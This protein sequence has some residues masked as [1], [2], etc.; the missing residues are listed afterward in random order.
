VMFTELSF[1]DLKKNEPGFV[2]IGVN[3]KFQSYVQNT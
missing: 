1:W 3:G 2:S